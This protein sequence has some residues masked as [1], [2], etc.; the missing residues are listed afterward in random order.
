VIGWTRPP[1]SFGLKIY[2]TRSFD[3]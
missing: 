3:I 2:V 1:S